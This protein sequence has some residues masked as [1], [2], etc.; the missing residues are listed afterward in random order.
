ME[1]TIDDLFPG[2]WKPS[3]AGT[4]LTCLFPDPAGTSQGK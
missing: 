3:W 1:I 4:V 2:G